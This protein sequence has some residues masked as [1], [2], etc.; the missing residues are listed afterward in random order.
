M[1]LNGFLTIRGIKSKLPEM[2]K[3]IN[4]RAYK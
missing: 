1:N 4:D 2:I 3:A